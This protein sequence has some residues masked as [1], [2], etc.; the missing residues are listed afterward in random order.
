MKKGPLMLAAAAAVTTGLIT[1]G[2]VRAEEA[3][4]VDQPV[5]STV[6]AATTPTPTTT[7]MAGRHGGRGLEQMAETLGLSVTDLQAKLDAGT[8][9]YKIAVEQGLTYTKLLE[10][11]Q[12]EVTTRVNDMVSSGFMTK[13][14][15][16]KFLTA[17]Q[18][19]AADGEMMGMMGLG[20]GGRG[21]GR[22]M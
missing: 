4:T 17:W 12:A 22:G 7:P 11:K 19:R 2:F 1:A 15:G 21:M 3:S 14:Q 13:E 10:K 5:T 8:P 9:M 16:D 20:H 18:E 6:A